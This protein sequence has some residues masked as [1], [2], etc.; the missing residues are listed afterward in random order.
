MQ[1]TGEP[2]VGGAAAGR[3]RKAEDDADAAEGGGAKRAKGEGGAVVD[4][5]DPAAG[6]LQGSAASAPATVQFSIFDDD[7]EDDT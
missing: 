4:G 7:S 5:A 6:T 1:T 3:K 2:E